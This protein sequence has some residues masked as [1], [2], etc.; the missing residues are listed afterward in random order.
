MNGT[1]KVSGFALLAL[2]LILGNAR[3]A[4]AQAPAAAQDANAP[5]Y[6]LAEYNSYKAC[7]GEANPAAK[8][9]CLD[10]FV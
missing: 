3:N 1:R 2:G 10:D 6:T 9:K 5:K 4:S 8:I 7:E